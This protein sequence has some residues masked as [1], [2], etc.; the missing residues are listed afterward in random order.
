VRRQRRQLLWAW[1]GVFGFTTYGQQVNAIFNTKSPSGCRRSDNRHIVQHG[2]CGQPPA[3]R[4][5]ILSFRE[6]QQLPDGYY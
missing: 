3:I 4:Q 1:F 5:Q 2:M 6:F